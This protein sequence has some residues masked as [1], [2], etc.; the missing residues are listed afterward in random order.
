ME[1][2][3][4]ERGEKIILSVRKH[5]LVFLV[6]LLPYALLAVAPMLISALAVW[7]GSVYPSAE[8]FAAT[9][10]LGNPSVRLALGL[11]WL[12]LWMGAFHTFTRYYLEQWVVTTLRIVNIRQRGFFRREVSSF[13]L[14]RVQDVTTTVE[15]IL[16]TLFGFGTIRV[17]T[18]GEEAQHFYLRG[19]RNPEHMRDLIMREIAE[20]EKSHGL[21]GV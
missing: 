17:E 6:E 14:E 4:L 5:W 16:P 21:K 19:I 18:A 15:G 13:L 2:F 1:E 7:A 3:E 12:A 10:T 20:L 8:S 11:W 9:L